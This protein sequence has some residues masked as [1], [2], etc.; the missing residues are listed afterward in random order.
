MA[1]MSLKDVEVLRHVTFDAE[2]DQELSTA[3]LGRVTIFS[4][5]AGA[6]KVAFELQMQDRRRKQMQE[7][8]RE[9]V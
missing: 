2:V 7:L 5:A 3:Q 9:G 8:F 1:K 4:S 6:V